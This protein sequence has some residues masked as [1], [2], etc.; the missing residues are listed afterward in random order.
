SDVTSMLRLSE[1]RVVGVGST[2]GNIGSASATKIRELLYA[3]DFYAADVEAAD[4]YDVEMGELG[5]RPFAW[6]HLLIGSKLAKIENG[7][8][9]LSRS[10][11]KALQLP[12][13][14]VIRQLWVAWLEN[15][16]F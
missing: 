8:L 4:K 1:Q 5:I 2:T 16:L 10:G 6:P 3:G 9:A 11:T 7:K 12:P 15:D 13:Q 14:E